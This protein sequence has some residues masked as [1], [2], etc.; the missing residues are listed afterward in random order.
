MRGLTSKQVQVLE[1]IQHSL[2]ERGYP[3]TLRE[4]G[5]QMGIKS[6]NGVND[7][8]KALETKGYLTRDDMK[9]RSLRLTTR[10]LHLLEQP[11]SE[12]TG[13]PPGFGVVP[14]GLGSLP[15]SFAGAAANEAGEPA[16]VSEARAGA[17][18]GRQAPNM[19]ATTKRAAGA[20]SS[21]HPGGARGASPV[22]SPIPP[23]G[24]L[25]WTP[26]EDL[27]DIQ[28]LG[29]VA[30]GL[31]ILADENI[32]D[33]VR[34]DRGMLNLSPTGAREVFG[35]R[36]SGDSMIEAGIQHG[37]YLFVRRVAAPKRGEI[38]VALIGEEATVKY[39]FPEKDHIRFQP[40]NSQMAP[41]YVR[42]ADVR[43]TTILGVVVGIYRRL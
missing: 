22:G 3:P 37:D 16:G 8:L 5:T 28:V 1:F 33:T 2:R 24:P 9:S 20:G 41:I 19:S 31:P 29:R 35:L 36:V 17:S 26:P 42:A 27:V 11:P 21:G 39:Y 23:S 15:A 18:R 34:I 14:G 32:I 30:A 7:H 6:T 43:S 4:I 12:R 25:T 38:V 13:L 10:A 40:A